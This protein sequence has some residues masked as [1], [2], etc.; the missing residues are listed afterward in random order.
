MDLVKQ[1]DISVKIDRIFSEV[2]KNIQV[3]LPSSR[4]EHIGATAIPNSITKGDLDI[5]VGVSVAEF[6]N[7][8][9]AIKQLGFTE[10]LDTLRTDSLFMMV[11]DKYG[12][13]VAVQVV[14]NG[15]EFESFID[16]RD[17][18]RTSPNLVSEYNNIKQGAKSESQ[19]R[20]REIKSSFIKSVLAAPISC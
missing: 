10:K 19:E 9:K 1:S 5:F 13:D 12:E 16:F 15:S 2:E 11:S 7:A 4:I 14:A 6:D 3:A 18:L 8:I 17:K 20:Y